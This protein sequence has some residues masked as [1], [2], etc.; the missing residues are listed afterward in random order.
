MFIAW[1]STKV[2][3]RSM[4]KDEKSCNDKSDLKKIIRID[5]F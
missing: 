5:I 3:D 4:A 1:H 2:W